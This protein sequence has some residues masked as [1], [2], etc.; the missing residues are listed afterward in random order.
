MRD[1]QRLP[2]ML[3]AVASTQPELARAIG[4]NPEAFMQMIQAAGAGPGQD[5]VGQM[6]AAGGAGAGGPPPG[7]TV[8]RL[9]E[10]ERAA[11]ERLMSLGFDRN[12]VLQAYLACDKNEEL[13]ANFLFDTAGD[14]M[15]D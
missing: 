3:Q 5:P 8:V 12:A 2:A 9:T 7:T 4:E 14:A 15:G 11:V 1:P 10:D 6:M 13:A